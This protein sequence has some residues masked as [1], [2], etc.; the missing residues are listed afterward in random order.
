MEQAIAEQ[1]AMPSGKTQ[2]WLQFNKVNGAFVMVL[3][4]DLDV[5]TLNQEFFTYAQAE[6]DFENDVVV[7]TADNYQIVAKTDLPEEIYESHLDSLARDKITKVYP[8]IQQVNLVGKAT[9]ALDQNIVAIGERLDK[10][11]ALLG[12][13]EALPPL[14][15]QSV[16]AE[17]VEMQN[18]IDEVKQANALRK[19]YY[20]ESDAHEYISDEAVQAR[21]DAV[22]EGG[23]HEAYGPRPSEGGRVF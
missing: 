3:S 5:G 4:G 13:S 17:L 18:Y 2:V 7:G 12:E 23:L 19:Q 20:Q 21:M 11:V 8:V 16:T 9:V 15:L 10:L 6:F 22:L 14:A 1:Y